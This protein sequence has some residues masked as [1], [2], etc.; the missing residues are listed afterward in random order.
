MKNPNKDK[1]ENLEELPNVGK[2]IKKY[3]LAININHP[4]DLIGQDALMIYK[5][6]CTK[7]DTLY[8]PCVIDVFMSIV[9]FMKTGEARLWW[10]FTQKR[11]MLYP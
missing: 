8:N 5:R 11:K 1:I 4:K 9:D 10:K 7:H 2:T 3:L 6:L